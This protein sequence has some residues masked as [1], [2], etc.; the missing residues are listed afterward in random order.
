M[1]TNL[2]LLLWRSRIHQNKMAQDMQIDEA[3]LSRI[4]NGFREPTLDQRARIAA[5]LN[6]DEEWLFAR[7][8]E[9]RKKPNLGSIGIT[10]EDQNA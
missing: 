10:R 9:I 1:Y 4:I 5:Y 2:K 8:V 3:V 7:D 6:V